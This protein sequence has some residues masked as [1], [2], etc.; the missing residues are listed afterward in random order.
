MEY[1]EVLPNLKLK[2]STRNLNSTRV[3]LNIKAQFAIESSP[4]LKVDIAK[5]MN[6]NLWN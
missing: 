1:W 2:E 4:M 3:N 6:I 5:K